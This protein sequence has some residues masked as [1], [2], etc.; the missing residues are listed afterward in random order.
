MSALPSGID[1]SGLSVLAPGDTVLFSVPLAH[2]DDRRA[3]AFS[4]SY[5]KENDE[6]QLEDYG[7]PRRVRLRRPAPFRLAFPVLR[8]ANSELSSERLLNSDFSREAYTYAETPDH[9]KA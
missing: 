1:V 3:I 8:P 7:S 6:H 5:V 2:L 9:R 4:Y